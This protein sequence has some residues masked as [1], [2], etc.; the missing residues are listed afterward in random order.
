MIKDI[1]NAKKVKPDLVGLFTTGLT[2]TK[3]DDIKG[4]DTFRLHI[5]SEMEQLNN[6]ADNNTF[7]I[8]IDNLFVHDTQSKQHHPHM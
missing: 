3:G 2:E 7:K 5:S 6:I 8:T 1:G 4:A